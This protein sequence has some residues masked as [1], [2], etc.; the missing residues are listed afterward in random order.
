MLIV[1]QE[2][3][4]LKSI[5]HY[6][7]LRTTRFNS[8]HKI[9]KLK[10]K[11]HN[12]KMNLT[13]VWVMFRKLGPKINWY[14]QAFIKKWKMPTWTNRC[15]KKSTRMN[16][17]VLSNKWLRKSRPSGGLALNRRLYLTIYA[18]YRPWSSPKPSSN[19]PSSCSVR[20]WSRWPSRGRLR[21][22]V[23]DIW[24]SSMTSRF[25]G[26]PPLL[27]RRWSMRS[28][29]SG[30]LTVFSCATHRKCL[31]KR[32]LLTLSTSCLASCGNT[33]RSSMPSPRVS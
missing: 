30:R 33:Q 6:W 17:L 4:S 16:F 28:R 11:N 20:R 23:K 10:S 31:G 9:Y 3:P 24:S 26:G 21:A 8:S 32:T 5:I 19:R 12:S 27:R 7:H 29:L 15:L 14:N 18:S 1:K 2:I 22:T 25:S 13:Q